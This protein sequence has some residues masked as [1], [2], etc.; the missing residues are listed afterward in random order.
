M[1]TPSQVYKRFSNIILYY[2]LRKVDESC[3]DNWRSEEIKVFRV[4]N[5]GVDDLRDLFI[6]Y[7]IFIK[8][9][10]LKESFSSRRRQRMRSH[11]LM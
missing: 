1:T 10:T 9:D 6:R 3:C 11:Y 2:K 7:E 8:D 5:D 4:S